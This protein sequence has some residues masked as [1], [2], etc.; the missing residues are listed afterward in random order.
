[1]DLAASA[2]PTADWIGEHLY[3]FVLL[4]TIF[5]LRP[6]R[7][8]WL[9]IFHPDSSSA[10]YPI[11]NMQIYGCRPLIRRSGKSH[12]GKLHSFAVI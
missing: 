4:H 11:L 9:A 2:A 7:T 5:D 10:I 3:L 6:R 8:S 12:A 1:M